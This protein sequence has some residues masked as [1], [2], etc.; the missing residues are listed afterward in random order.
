MIDLNHSKIYSSLLILISQEQFLNQEFKAL[1]RSYLEE[2]KKF[3]FD[4]GVLCVVH[5]KEN[6]SKFNDD[7][8]DIAAALELIILSFDIIDDLQDSDTENIWTHKPKFSLNATLAMMNIANKVIRQSSFEF[9]GI[10]IELIE[11]YTLISINGQQLDLQNVCQDEASYL[12]MIKQKSGSLTALSCL[13]GTV[14]AKGYI[15]NEVEEYASA[16]GIIQQIKN[17]IKDLKE[18]NSKNDLLNKRFSLPII[19]LFAL[20]N[21]RSKVI[22]DYYFNNVN[23]DLRS[24]DILNFIEQ[25]GS[26]IYALSIKNSYK[27]PALELLENSDFS[28]ESVDYIKKLMK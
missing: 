13:V 2:K 4:F 9:R 10:A 6:V 8:Y 22:K 11:K 28:C 21:Q 17:D 5:Y 26:I 19:Y 7:I 18:W 27:Y 20:N 24:N 23:L 12:E 16:L 3:G 15:V 25:S 14:L 1:I